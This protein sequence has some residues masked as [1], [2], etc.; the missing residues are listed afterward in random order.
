MSVLASLL[1]GYRSHTQGDRLGSGGSHRWVSTIVA[2]LTCLLPLALSSAWGADGGPWRGADEVC[3]KSL[4]LTDEESYRLLKQWVL[5]GNDPTKWQLWAFRL[6]DGQTFAGASGKTPQIVSLAHGSRLAA[7]A[8]E[9][10]S[11]GQRLKR[12]KELS[13]VVDE[14]LAEGLSARRNRLAMQILLAAL[15]DNEAETES[16]VELATARLK[17]QYE[18]I[19]SIDPPIGA[20]TTDA[21]QLVVLGLL[22]QPA[23]LP[24]A[25]SLTLLLAD[26]SRGYYREPQ[27][28][29]TE[30]S[31][32]DTVN[33]RLAEM[34]SLAEER[35]VTPLVMHQWHASPMNTERRTMQGEHSSRWVIDRGIAELRSGEMI[36]PLFFQSPLTG[37]FEVTAEVTNNDWKESLLAYDMIGY[38]PQFNLNGINVVPV[39]GQRTQFPKPLTMPRWDQFSD[40]RIVVKE[41]RMSTQINGVEIQAEDLKPFPDP[42][43][44]LSSLNPRCN[45][46]VRNV[47]ILGNPTIPAEINLSQITDLV[48]W[49]ADYFGDRLGPESDEQADW[50]QKDGEIVSR[51]RAGRSNGGPLSL[52]L[53]QRPLSPDSELSYEFFAAAAA[54]D[55]CPAL[56]SIVWLLSPSGVRVQSLS[57]VRQ[58]RSKEKQ[59]TSP[60]NP[61]LA[62]KIKDW[63]T[64]RLSIKAASVT[65]FLNDTKIDEQTLDE[66]NSRQFGLFRFREQPSCRIRNVIWHGDWPRAL[67][68]LDEQELALPADGVP[69]REWPIN[70]TF[71]LNQPLRALRRLGV[72]INVAEEF[73]NETPEGTEVRSDPR[74]TGGA[75]TEL[76]WIRAL[77]GDF[78]VTFS[79]KDVRLVA[80]DPP[81][82]HLRVD[83]ANEINRTVSIAVGANREG[84]KTLLTDHIRTP[85]D[86]SYGM[87][88]WE[89]NIPFVG[90]RLRLVRRGG[91]VFALY[92]HENEGFQILATHFVGNFDV[93]AI[94]VWAM[95]HGPQG[96]I[97]AV[98]RELTIR[99][100]ELLD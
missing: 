71:K 75:N 29:Q 78:D 36:S 5:P 55:I 98:C 13:T 76:A 93:S 49:R 97:Q 34:P 51:P 28:Q 69:A 88:R 9:L 40:V 25:Q 20:Q 91:E 4:D 39:M 41:R 6:V 52:L 46:S 11:V 7:P 26:K 53:H 47:R 2:S 44:V 24:S 84:Q 19:K 60:A 80:P 21:E 63:N 65:L 33:Q 61:A 95:V 90:G 70:G 94:K 64:I 57:T 54:F 31:L 15:D 89:K 67:P 62:L 87:I 72:G 23:W 56:G 83:F 3:R 14:S 8:L 45:S 22:D 37:D 42:W 96:E 77:R 16:N 85:P 66:Q 59:K 81:E 79:V 35:Y 32:R 10:I 74:R 1:S 48:N 12:L 17:D 50:Y 27:T 100:D 73:Y 92:A 38:F 68:S 82:L 86:S 99:A 18:L 30:R 58:G 43:I